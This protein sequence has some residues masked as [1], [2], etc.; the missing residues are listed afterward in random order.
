MRSVRTVR[1]GADGQRTVVH[2]VPAVDVVDIAVAVAVLTVL[3]LVGIDPH[4]G[5]QVGMIPLHAVVDH[6]DHDPRI[7]RAELPRLVAVDVGAG[8]NPRIEIRIARIDVVPLLAQ[9][10]IVEVHGRTALHRRRPLFQRHGFAAADPLDVPVELHD[11]HFGNRSQTAGRF[12]E[13]GSGVELDEVPAVQPRGTRTRLVAL[14]HRE[15]TPQRLHADALEHRIEII[16]SRTGRNAARTGH[17]QHRRFDGLDG[18]LVETDQQF[19]LHGIVGREEELGAHLV[20]RSGPGSG[21]EF[22]LGTRSRE[23]RRREQQAPESS[24]LCHHH[25]IIW[26]T[27]LDRGPVS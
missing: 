8:A 27:P 9:I 21:I 12:G 7:A 19:A 13:I 23:D 25:K 1:P 24:F 20:R 14:V 10:G 18:R 26:L 15:E 11:M 3:R 4:V 2:E 17:T 22:L 5:G 6:G 16:D